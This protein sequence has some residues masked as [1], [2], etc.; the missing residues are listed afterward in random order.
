MRKLMRNNRWS[1]SAP[2]LFLG[3]LVG[4]GNGA[5]PPEAPAPEMSPEASAA[6]ALIAR[7]LAY[8]DPGGV[9]ETAEI[10]L[11]ISESR[12]G[13]SDRRTTLA[14]KPAGG[15]MTVAR[16]SEGG[17]T[18]FGVSGDRIVH[19]SAAGRS[20]LDEEGFAEHGLDP[21]RVMWLR[22]YYLF[23][24]GLPMKLRDPGTIVD[25]APTADAY[26]GQEALKV[27]VT[28]DPEV[29]GDTWYFYFDPESAR[30]LGYRFYHDEAANDGEYIH[31]AGEIE[32][33]GLRLP[34]T[35]RWYM[36]QDDRFLGEDEAVSLTV[37]P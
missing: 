5:P 17:E 20:D 37:M 18:S 12:P 29:G 26:D 6:E 33:G 22:N 15:T 24:W 11:E 3:V 34:A 28:Y 1:A 14:M 23:V 2:A 32:D 10:A 8:H 13:G 27:R 21:E 16:E 36:H 30:L 25:P 4:C 31:L 9:W 35:R 19:R 7:S